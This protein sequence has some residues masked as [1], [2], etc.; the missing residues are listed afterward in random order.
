MAALARR[1]LLLF[2]A[3]A[4]T[5]PAAA[6]EIRLKDGKKLNGNIVGYEDNMF[7][8]K[9]DFGFV[10]VEKD[11]IAA[12]IPTTPA[13][14]KGSSGSNGTAPEAKPEP[15][16]AAKKET[17]PEPAK[18]APKT[19]ALK[20]PGETEKNAK[21]AA[22][23]APAAATAQQAGAAPTT[24]AIVA[25]APPKAPE[26]PPNR[27]EVRGNEYFNLTYGF[28]MY[29]APSWDLIPNARQ[30]LPNA[31]VAMG[32][33]DEAT[34]L[35]IGHEPLKEP[36]DASAAAFE[37]RL[38]DVYENYRRLGQKNTEVAG[39]P[40]VEYRYRGLADGHDWSG[41]LVAIARGNEIFTIL[42]MTYADSDLIQ[43]QENVMS[44]AIAS[45]NFAAQ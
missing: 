8:V 24:A 18:H 37:K 3:C 11:K 45:I 7:R 31:I 14:A 21:A 32:T 29:K 17:P 22:P 38:E 2:A 4:F 33:P 25:P 40:A 20:K 43:I 26:P 35:V 27:E 10:L 9:T 1:A 16:P 12:I 13:G 28:R 41:R 19:A 44:K 42:G 6:D 39:L 15:K 36:L 30:A 34:L 5:L 23:S